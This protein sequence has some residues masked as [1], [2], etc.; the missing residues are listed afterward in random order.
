MYMLTGSGPLIHLLIKYLLI[1]YS[2]L[3]ATF[4]A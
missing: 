2:I 1:N 4:E 3:G